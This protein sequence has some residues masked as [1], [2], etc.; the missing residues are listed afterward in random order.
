MQQHQLFRYT[1]ALIS[2]LRKEELSCT[3]K[4]LDQRKLPFLSQYYLHSIQF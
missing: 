4:G 3:I 2:H 1:L